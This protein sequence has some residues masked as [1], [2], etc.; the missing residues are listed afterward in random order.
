VREASK[1][2]GKAEGRRKEARVHSQAC[3]GM[4]TRPSHYNT[5]EG[6]RVLVRRPMRAGRKG[7]AR[8]RQWERYRGSRPD[9]PKTGRYAGDEE[10]VAARDGER[11]R[12]GARARAR[13]G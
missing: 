13:G 2:E 9:G 11:R 1:G 3:V 10:L 4:C 7:P 5:D 12:R 6:S 8:W